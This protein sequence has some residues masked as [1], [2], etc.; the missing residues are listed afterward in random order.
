MQSK[1]IEN[2]MYR[3]DI[4]GLRA[5][6]VLL[7]LVYHAFPNYL[8]GGFIGVDV[9]F[10][11]SGYL[12]SKNIFNHID[13]KDFSIRNFYGRRIRRIFPSL[14]TILLASLLIG[15]FR[16]LPNDLIYLAK[17]VIAS[18]LFISNIFLWFNANYFDQ[19]SNLNPLLHVWSL[20]VE[21]QF[22][23]FWPLILI[24]I[25]KKKYKKNIVLI[26]SAAS[27]FLSLYLI[28]LNPVEAFFSPLPRFWELLAGSYLN[29][30]ERKF[31]TN[32]YKKYSSLAGLFLIFF[33]ALYID[34]S[35]LFPGLLVALPV[36]GACLII[37]GNKKCWVNS[38]LSNSIFV[39]IGLISY[40]LYLWHWT[41]LSFIRILY[42]NPLWHLRL[43]ALFLSVVCAYI[44]Y[45]FIE[46]PIRF[47]S[48]RL[49]SPLLLSLM[50]IIF[51]FAFSICRWGYFI[52]A[53]TPFQ[54]K[55]M[56]SSNIEESYRYK[57]CFLDPKTQLAANFLSECF[58][59]TNINS[60]KVLIWGDS[61]AAQLYPGLKNLLL[62][63]PNNNNLI[64]LTAGSC[65]PG[66]ETDHS[67]NGNCDDINRYVRKYIETSQPEIVLI[68]GR[69]EN[70]E[71][72]YKYRIRDTVAFLKQNKVKK[73]IL[74][75][76]APDWSPDLKKILLWS[77]YDETSLPN[78]MIPPTYF[79]NSTKVF[80]DSLYYL[81]KDLGIDFISP[82]DNFCKGQFC[83][84]RISNNI[85]D[86]LVTYD[87]DHLTVEASEYLFSQESVVKLFKYNF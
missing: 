43:A 21:E 68:N 85:P 9:F 52:K 19:A 48:S 59:I 70:S 46:K 51:V 8:H 58:S 56:R 29:F 44:T 3:S 16:L 64:Q 37:C 32:W 62:K 23:I 50:A 27:F 40:P 87:H 11:I 84:I 22:Y 39:G 73:I 75:G 66:S 42:P 67:N 81:S 45:K 53:P 79:W 4:D 5:L 26:I 7:V 47:N 36:L 17:N 65:P 14:I 76:P 6:A 77:K 63:H 12:I 20:G 13:N 2:E 31:I 69:W 35:K 54:E 49:V 30:V 83:L 72:N 60:P 86:G 1:K 15:Y 18:S 57:R 38:T 33:S 10:V 24:F 41:I 55:L 25:C 78:S 74:V 71:R 28:T 61:L 82:I 80:N 34:D